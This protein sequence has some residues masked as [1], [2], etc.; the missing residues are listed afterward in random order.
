MRASPRVCVIVPCRNEV[1]F[2]GQCIDSIIGNDY[3][4]DLLEVIV[5][6][7]MSDDGTREVLA[8]LQ[9]RVPFLNVI[10][11]PD[12]TTAKALNRALAA[13]DADVIVRVDAHATIQCFQ[14]LLSLRG[15]QSIAYRRRGGAR[16][17]GSERLCLCR[18]LCRTGE[19]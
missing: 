10:A 16:S 17:F 12:R 7:G 2:I 4:K 19:D 5:V 3:H 15:P 11:N 8:D 1:R 6:D 13:T 9:T 18:G 14:N